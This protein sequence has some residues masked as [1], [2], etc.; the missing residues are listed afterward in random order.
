[1]LKNIG[2]RRDSHYF[3]LL[4]TNLKKHYLQQVNKKE[5]T[6]NVVVNDQ[7]YRH[8]QCRRR[9]MPTPPDDNRKIYDRK[10]ELFTFSNKFPC[11]KLCR[12]QPTLLGKRNKKFSQQKKTPFF[13]DVEWKAINSEIFTINKTLIRQSV[14]LSKPQATNVWVGHGKKDAY[15]IDCFSLQSNW[16]R[17][18]SA[19][20]MN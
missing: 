14:Q 13:V 19:Y 9:C 17:N 12:E 5:L 1:M 11:E 10:W 16:S 18:W 7:C 4:V 20:D 3:F 6:I 8:D 15:A 2:D